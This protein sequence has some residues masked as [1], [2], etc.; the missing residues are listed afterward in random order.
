MNIS[1]VE[2]FISYNLTKDLIK[3]GVGDG[4]EFELIYQTVLDSVK[5]R[6]ETEEPISLSTL[7][8]D[9]LPIK[10]TGDIYGRTSSE[11]K[12]T[13]LP[14]D[15]TSEI[16]NSTGNQ[17]EQIVEAVDK[18]S[19]KYGVDKNLLLAIIKQESNFSPNAESHAGAKGLMQLMDFNSE[20]Y[21]ITNP[22]DID[23]NVMGGT[24]HIK[25]CLDMFNGDV[26]MALM[27]Y[28]AGQGTMERRGVTKASDLYKMP[29][30]TQNYVPKVMRNYKNN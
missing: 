15:I 22:F 27:A 10:N 23:Q 18:Y 2:D 3:Q 30:E 16:S 26:E 13:T 6:E 12:I 7:K 4:M 21:G 11:N 14:T 19:A 25:K 8:L 17:Y 20:S 1:K 28:N 29:E 5:N 9:N 24:I